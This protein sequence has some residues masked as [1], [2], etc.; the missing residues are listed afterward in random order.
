MW[1]TKFQERANV[2]WPTRPINKLIM[3]PLKEQGMKDEEEDVGDEQEVRPREKVV[4]E[5]VAPQPGGRE[6]LQ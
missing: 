5:E 3:G 4:S 1:S 2:E 6:F